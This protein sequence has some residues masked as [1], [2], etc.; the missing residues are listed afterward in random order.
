[1]YWLFIKQT[2]QQRRS[3]ALQMSLKYWVT[4][5]GGKD[6]WSRNWADLAT[7]R[8]SFFFFSI[9]NSENVTFLYWYD[10]N[11]L[12]RMRLP[13]WPSS[14][15]VRNTLRLPNHWTNCDWVVI[16]QGGFY[17]TAGR[18]DQVFHRRARTISDAHFN[19][20]FRMI[21]LSKFSP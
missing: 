19:S 10:W 21:L 5:V 9:D 15:H 13:L 20:Q 11:K 4:N 8:K 2:K 7:N 6:Q 12:R 1:M 16:L 14:C 3:I 18:N 17:L